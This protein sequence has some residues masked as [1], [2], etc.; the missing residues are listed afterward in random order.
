MFGS[1]EIDAL[2]SLWGPFATMPFFMLLAGTTAPSAERA[3]AAHGH[4]ADGPA[5]VTNVLSSAGRAADESGL[6]SG[7]GRQS[8]AAAPPDGG[9]PSSAPATPTAG[10]FR[11]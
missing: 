8:E 5:P 2:L 9:R 1:A 10:R 4:R 11:G 3:L 7:D 6:R